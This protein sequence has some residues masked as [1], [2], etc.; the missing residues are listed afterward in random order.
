MHAVPDQFCL[1]WPGCQE[2]VF[3]RVPDVPAER[4]RSL[5]NQ[6]HKGM[7]FKWVTVEDLFIFF[8]FFSLPSIILRAPRYPLLRSPSPGNFICRPSPWATCFHPTPGPIC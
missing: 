6:N 2:A 5:E 8:S 4:P 3:G 7:A 1:I